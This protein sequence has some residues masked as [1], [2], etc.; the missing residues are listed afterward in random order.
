MCKVV[1]THCVLSRYTQSELSVCNITANMS[2]CNLS[3]YLLTQTQAYSSVHATNMYLQMFTYT[4]THVYVKTHTHR[5]DINQP[6]F[7]VSALPSTKNTFPQK[8]DDLRSR[9]KVESFFAGSRNLHSTTHLAECMCGELHHSD[10]RRALPLQIR[11]REMERVGGS[12]SLKQ[13][14]VIWA[15]E[16]IVGWPRKIL[17]RFKHS[18]CVSVCVSVCG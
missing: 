9:R 17:A 12:R 18:V 13:P 14:S 4:Y 3:V 7:A 11:Q 5:Y 15:D 1:Y 16:T 2:T 10:D 8:S 6:V